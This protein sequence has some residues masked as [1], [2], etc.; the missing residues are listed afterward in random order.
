MNSP[1]MYVS[2]IFST[3]YLVLFCVTAMLLDNF[4]TTTKGQL[5]YSFPS[6]VFSVLTRPC[7][8]LRFFFSIQGGG[9]I[10]NNDPSVTASVFL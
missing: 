4:S 5:L 2:H 3:L 10:L 9:G 6:H 7:I 8:C 1:C